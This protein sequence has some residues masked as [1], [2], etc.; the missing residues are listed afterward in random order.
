MVMVFQKFLKLTVFFTIAL[1]ISISSASADGNPEG[2]E[3]TATI[4]QDGG[5]K[6]IPEERVTVSWSSNTED[7]YLTKITLYNL[8]TK[9]SYNFRPKNAAPA[10]SG[11]HSWTVGEK[12]NGFNI[13]PGMY[14]AKTILDDVAL[15]GI[16]ATA[17][18]DPFEITGASNCVMN[19]TKIGEG[20][21]KTNIDGVPTPVTGPIVWSSG[22]KTINFVPADDWYVY[23]VEVNNETLKNPD[24]SL[25]HPS[26]YSK[27]CDEPGTY[28]VEVTFSIIECPIAVTHTSGG[29]VTLTRE[30]ANGTEIL[31][32]SYV[33]PAGETV[34]VFSEPY[35]SYLINK[36]NIEIEN[37]LTGVVSK[38]TEGKDQDT[39]TRNFSCPTST[40]KRFKTETIFKKEGQCV[41]TAK[42]K[43]IGGTIDPE[44][45]VIL[46]NLESRTFRFEPDEGWEVYK[47]VVNDETY[48]PKP[49]HTVH[50]SDSKDF[51]VSVYFDAKPC[52]LKTKAGEGGRIDPDTENEEPYSIAVPYALEEMIRIYPD[53][54][55]GYVIED[56]TLNS[57][58][59][60]PV[61]LVRA[62]CTEP[63]GDLDVKASFVWEGYKITSTN[64]SNKSEGYILPLGVTKLPFHKTQEFVID[65]AEDY[66][67]EWV[68]IDGE[69]DNNYTHRAGIT[70]ITL[71]PRSEAW[72]NRDRTIA[73]KFIL[74]C[75][76]IPPEQTLALLR[77]GLP[78]P[79]N[80]PS[81]RT[82]AD[83]N[84]EL[85]KDEMERY[86]CAYQ[87]DLGDDLISSNIMRTHIKDNLSPLLKENK[88]AVGVF[89]IP[90]DVEVYDRYGAF[91]RD[92]EDL[93]SHSVVITDYRT[94]VLVENTPPVTLYE[95]D[96]IDS[97]T[98]VVDTLFC[99]DEIDNFAGVVI[100]CEIPSLY[101]MT[102]RYDPETG[103]RKIRYATG[104]WLAGES[105]SISLNINALNL[106][107]VRG[108]SADWI[109][110]NFTRF[111]NFTSEESGVGVC[112]GWAQ[113]NQRA[114]LLI[115]ECK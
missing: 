89:Y 43:G 59:L 77:T 72:D 73:V 44:G 92:E 93:I 5:D 1:L 30:T 70:K 60:G 18:T 16:T 4:S 74:A 45:E 76:I 58:S 80:K 62:K 49:S 26:S 109:E 42:V 103:E 113:F 71:G 17:E 91:V 38:A 35:G 28:D 27:T 115:E 54:D 95:F 31:P 9:K 3:L 85:V 7:P 104:L 90:V 86:Q 87:Q 6:W 24:G 19:V 78:A 61:G 110:D 36:V 82:W 2:K 64:L 65:P 75:K 69:I 57:E 25:Q 48:D 102:V 12:L 52:H 39:H 29:E 67:I 83:E 56:V 22:Q 98:L 66:I 100:R 13:P 112:L 23:S 20:V 10:E 96:Y 32:D 79:I 37:L 105:G 63:D 47:V 101:E 107:A 15:D 33:I 40:P 8:G 111:S 94:E 55:E 14:I 81:F 84:E 108:N 99:I 41:V 21:V 114:A 11:S 106:P 46:Q 97:N 50:C 88:P 51:E 34:K 53:S 68:K